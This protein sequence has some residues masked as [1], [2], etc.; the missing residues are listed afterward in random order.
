MTDSADNGEFQNEPDDE[1]NTY[2]TRYKGEADD[3]LSTAVVK[4]VAEFLEL[5]PTE[6]DP[7]YEVFDPEVLDKLYEATGGFVEP[8]EEGSLTFTYSRCEVTVFWSGIIEV[9]PEGES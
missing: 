6:L 5:P 3:S 8:E 9:R 7:L 2:R 4:A 1:T